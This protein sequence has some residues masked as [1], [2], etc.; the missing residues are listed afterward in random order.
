MEGVVCYHVL[1]EHVSRYHEPFA[2]EEL[3]FQTTSG[4]WMGGQPAA[5][6]I[7]SAQLDWQG[8][9]FKEIDS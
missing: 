7:L 8:Y 2:C 1:P 9:N 3:M 5:D 4:D 6:L